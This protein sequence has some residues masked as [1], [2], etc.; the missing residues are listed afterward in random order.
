MLKFI[1]P[2]ANSIFGCP[3]PIGV[4]LLTRIRL[5]LSHLREHKFKCSFH[6]TFNPLCSYGKKVKTTFPERN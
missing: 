5:G 4:K 1:R 6:D 2:T 3:N